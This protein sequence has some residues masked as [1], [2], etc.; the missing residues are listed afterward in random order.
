MDQDADTLEQLNA[1]LRR[2]GYEVRAAADGYAALLLARASRPDL[3]VSDLLLAG[4]DGY[5]VWKMLRAEK[6]FENVP[7][8]VVSSLTLPPRNKPWR[9]TPQTGWQLL[10]YDAFLPKPLD[11][12][13]FLR[14]VQNL[15]APG[16]DAGI[17]TG[18]SLVLAVQDPALQRRLVDFFAP[19][20]FGLEVSDSLDQTLRL[21]QKIPPA[22]LLL[23]Y[24]TPSDEVL[25]L[26]RRIKKTVPYTTIILLVELDT[27]IIEDMEGSYDDLVCTSLQSKLMVS[28]INRIL[29]L[30]TMERRT[31]AISTGLMVTNRDL[32]LTR[33]TLEAQNEELAYTNTRLRE[34]DSLKEM[35]TGMVVHD[36]K[37]PL[38]AVL[39]TLTFLITTPKVSL[40]ENIEK[41]VVGSVA[42]G[43][44]L[45]RLIE[46]L[47]EG[48][49]LED[50]RM[51]PDLEPFDLSGLFQVSMQQIGPLLAL[52]HLHANSILEKDPPL[53]Y[54]DQ[55]ISQRILENLLDN[56]IKFSPPHSTIT[57]KA[58]PDNGFMRISVAD[59][60][61]GISKE[62]QEEVFNRFVQL[63][64]GERH[65][66]R[67]GFGLGLAFCQLATQAMG[68]SIWVES[69]G[70]SGTTFTFTLPLYQE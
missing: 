24:R 40:P 1:I 23:D 44:Q 68:G 31:N 56:A 39:S 5:E 60:G 18:P 2:E 7:I 38:G 33:Q 21:I 26:A 12:R 64:Q 3:I 13:R 50:G 29:S 67:A 32:Q 54:A 49:R 20:G 65:T 63:K 62:H 9:P 46:T 69:D 41:L 45:L 10:Q 19:E 11:L 66:S 37:A 15:L 27:E 28:T 43:N 47:L 58:E 59:Q 57:L 14:V 35:L 55:H 22:A 70:E 42:A 51:K 4:L 16:R 34:L 6:E 52:H 36:L 8:L 61:P 30:A 25:A 53:V 48:Q 17:P